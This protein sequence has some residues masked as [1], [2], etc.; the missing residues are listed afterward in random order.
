[1]YKI[2]LHN[3]MYSMNLKNSKSTDAISHPKYI[4]SESDVKMVAAASLGIYHG[5]T[6]TEPFQ[7]SQVEQIVSDLIGANS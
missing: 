7:K 6:G 3:Y 1:M 4:K 5:S 2:Y